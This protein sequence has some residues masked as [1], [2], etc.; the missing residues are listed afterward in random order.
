MK[1]PIAAG[2]LLLAMLVNGVATAGEPDP[3]CLPVKQFVASV[4]A[5]EIHEIAFHTSWGSNFKTENEAAFSAKKCLHQGYGPAKPACQA[6][7][8]HG[9]VEFSNTNA[10]RVVTCLVP[11]NHWGRHVHLEQGALSL[12]YGTD[13][14]AA[15]VTVSYETDEEMGGMVLRLRAA[16]Y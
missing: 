5:G 13:R 3:L 12:Q 10:E 4:S 6:L 11:S 1:V 16:G 2:N 14:H 15:D 9:A 7:M 8:D